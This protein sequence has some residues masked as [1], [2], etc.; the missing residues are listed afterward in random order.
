MRPFLWLVLLPVVT[1]IGC[2]LLIR[3]MRR[4]A[5]V[6]TMV[7]VG[8]IGLA[9][10]VLD[11]DYAWGWLAAVLVLPLPIALTLGSVTLLKGRWGGDRGPKPNASLTTRRPS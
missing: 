6:A 5:Y 11:G 9:T 3:D 1:G 8:L 10:W 4:A 2:A 7:C